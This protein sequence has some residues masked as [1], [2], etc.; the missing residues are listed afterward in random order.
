MTY[1]NFTVGQLVTADLLNAALPQYVVKQT[2]Q[3][4][5]SS[6]SMIDD[7][8]LWYSLAPNATY[9]WELMVRVTGATGGDIRIEWAIPSGASMF[10]LCFG[11]AAGSND[12]ANA[13]GV[14][15][16]RANTTD[17]IYGIPSSGNSAIYERGTIITSSANGD[18]QMRWAQGT[19]N[20]EPTV[21]GSRSYLKVR[22]IA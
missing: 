14:F 16:Y 6:T 3:S 19:S 5:A 8:E 15:A 7:D 18:L 22:R 2:N 11:A 13:N 1:P 9:E 20:S 17:Q 12:Q 4:R 21:V 10:R